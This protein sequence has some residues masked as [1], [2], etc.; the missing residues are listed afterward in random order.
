MK[1]L[2]NNTMKTFLTTFLTAI[3]FVSASAFAKAETKS[4]RLASADSSVHLYIETITNGNVENID[5]LFS[6][7]FIQNTNTNGNLTTH[8]KELLIGFIR[9]QKNVKQDCSTTYTLLEKGGD[10]SIAKVEMK[11]RDFTKVDYVTL[12]KEGADWKVNQ[13]VTIYR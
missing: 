6:S 9:G 5:E 4:T 11:Y 13:V 1:T 8:N 2:K 3:L 10:Y 7:Q 12:T